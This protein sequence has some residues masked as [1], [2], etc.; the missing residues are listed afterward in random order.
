MIDICFRKEINVIGFA[1]IIILFTQLI[2]SISLK[3]LTLIFFNF[4]GKIYI[5]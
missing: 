3:G 5:Q 4:F 1:I 2:F